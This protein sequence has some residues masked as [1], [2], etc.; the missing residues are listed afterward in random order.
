[1]DLHIR[2]FLTQGNKHIN[3]ISKWRWSDNITYSECEW[4]MME[5]TVMPSFFFPREIDV[6]DFVRN[7]MLKK[8]R[9][10]SVENLNKI[11]QTSYT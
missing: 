9:E 10:F 5:H 1:M 8:P 11:V 7:K 4:M 6:F 3:I 2:R